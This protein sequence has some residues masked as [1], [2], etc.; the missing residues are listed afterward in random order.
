M[1]EKSRIIETLHSAMKDAP[2]DQVELVYDGEILNIT[3]IAE[4]EIQQN[5][6]RADASIVSRVVLDG[7]IGVAST[8]KLDVNSI[9]ACIADAA[10]ISKIS[11]PDESFTSLP[12]SPT[13]PSVDGFKQSTA[14][15][16]P[17]DRA[18]AVWM[19]NKAAA[20]K[21]LTT[22]GA[23]RTII[24]QIAVTNS[25][26]TEQYFE[27]TKAEFSLTVSA[28]DGR[29]GYAI[30]FDRDI[31]N[32][33]PGELVETSIDKAL[34]SENPVD[35]DSGQYTVILE[36]AA[37]G[38][39]LLFLAFMGFGSRTF[40]Q[41]RSFMA[42]SLGEQITSNL[43]TVRDNVY[44][45]RMQGMPFDYEGVVK[46]KVDLIVNGTATGVVSDS[47][48]ARKMGSESTGH[49]HIATKNFTPYPK[50]MVMEPGDWSVKDMI[51][52]VPRGIYITHFWYVNYLNPMRTMVTGLTRDG[53]FLVEE[54]KVTKPIV[55]MRMNQSI[56]EALMNCRMLSK[57]RKLYPQYSVVMLVPYAKIDNF[58]L[59]REGV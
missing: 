24:N 53:T 33:N 44:D 49:A 58:Q 25:L 41:H 46:K 32:I 20:M 8:N 42:G 15:A 28:E 22:A 52:S 38:Q 6:T 14:E 5:L 40:V 57:E 10:A 19:I 59:D 45:P 2:A 36:P 7:K 27:G 54:G 39:L 3:H 47:G 9:K 16:T 11:E 35:V 1:V 12:N 56:L 18:N 55:N 48:D 26:G 34:R 37:L 23:Y 50:H 43:I 13:A 17:S 4:S 21:K 51:G 30:A 31:D 29:S